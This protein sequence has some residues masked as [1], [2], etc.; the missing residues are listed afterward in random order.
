MASEDLP[1]NFDIVRYETLPA[2]R[3]KY[4]IFRQDDAV[5]AAFHAKYCIR[6]RRH[7]RLLERS[8]STD[9]DNDNVEGEELARRGCNRAES[10]EVTARKLRNVRLREDHEGTLPR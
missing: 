3:R 10:R 1:F 2:R 4:D 6:E 7:W 5:C 9:D 8:C